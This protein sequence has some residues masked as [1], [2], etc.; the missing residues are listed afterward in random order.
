MH[1]I[2][3]KC[4][5]DTDGS[6]MKSKILLLHFISPATT[7]FRGNVHLT[8]IDTDVDLDVDVDI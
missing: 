4:S 5:N 2:K 3:K 7:S 8:D 6:Q 1:I